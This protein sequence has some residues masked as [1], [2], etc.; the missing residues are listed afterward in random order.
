MAGKGRDWTT[1]VPTEYPVIHK[2]PS[3]KLI[4][5]DVTLEDWG[6][7]T[8]LVGGWALLHFYRKSKYAKWF[9]VSAVFAFVSIVGHKTAQ[10]MGM[11]RN[12]DLV[13]KYPF[14]LDDPTLPTVPAVPAVVARQE[15]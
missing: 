7:V 9:A 8:S 15:E 14:R 12:D 6:A 2:T 10:F 3:P 5:S 4:L 13:A 1:P 11:T